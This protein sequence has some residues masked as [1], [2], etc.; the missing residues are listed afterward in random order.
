MTNLA[1]LSDEDLVVE[2]VKHSRLNPIWFHENILNSKEN[3][4]WQEELYESVAD[5]WRKQKGIPTKYNHEGLNKITVR[6]MHGPGKTFGVAGTMHWFNYCFHGTIVCTAP[7][8]KQ[9]RT[10]LWPAFRKVM[11][12]ADEGYKRLMKVDTTKIVWCGDEDWVAHA[13]TAS[14][15]ENLAGYHADY[16][17]FIVDEATGVKEEMFPVIEGAVSTGKLVIIILIGNP[18]KNLGTFYDS[19]NRE[20]VSKNYHKI[21]VDL[22]KTT[23]VDRDWVRQMEDKYGKDSP[24]VQ[25]RC[26]GNFADTGENQVYALQWLIDAKNRDYAPDGSIPRLRV[27]VDVSDGGEDES[28]LTASLS[29]D[30]FTLYMKQ[31]RHSFPTSEAPILTAQAAARMYDAYVEEFN[32]DPLAGDIVIDSLG[33][34]AGAA[35]IL[36]LGVAQKDGTIKQYPVIN[37]KGGESSDNTNLWRN[38]RVQTHMVGRD[39]LRDGH[40]IFADDFCSEQDWEDFCAQMCSIH[41][42]ENNERVDDLETKQQMKARGIKSPDMAESWVMSHAAK[43]PTIPCNIVPEVF[44]ELASASREG[45]I[46]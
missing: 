3:D 35:G 36:I 1:T 15:P 13:E 16:L 24:V 26:Y 5:V 7:K 20:K 40:V 27:S 43:A 9:L 44:G 21:H 8:E 17:L 19:H 14:E 6:A 10:R 32:L 29:Y 12:K 4:P 31:T 18:T 46:T 30:S 25:I 38:R 39:E 34:G 41:R 2:A 22:E 11:T 33:V 37:Y 28:V 23:R 42:N 45:S